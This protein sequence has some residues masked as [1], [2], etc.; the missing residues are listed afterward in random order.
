MV[1]AVEAEDKEEEFMGLGEEEEE[2]ARGGR[3][4][5]G[6]GREECLLDLAFLSL[7]PFSCFPS[8]FSSPFPSPFPSP[9]SSP[10]DSRQERFRRRSW[11]GTADWPCR[12]VVGWN[13]G[14]TYSLLYRRITDANA[15]TTTS[16][17]PLFGGPMTNTDALPW[18]LWAVASRIASNSFW[19][20]LSDGRR[21][22]VRTRRVASAALRTAGA[23]EE[24]EENVEL[25][26][27]VEATKGSKTRDDSSSKA[28]G[29]P[30]RNRR[31]CARER[32]SE[33]V[34]P[35]PETDDEE[36]KRAAWE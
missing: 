14:R 2:A 11:G 4:G 3:G 35:D 21:G 29:W 17:L 30:R 20:R 6:G 1:A 8:N 32:P 27:E 26:D 25:G 5:T 36:G 23:K 16:D 10:S 34:T 19:A 31:R 18:S 15:R 7:S 28:V 9:F 33:R 13:L 24:E 12:T 22:R